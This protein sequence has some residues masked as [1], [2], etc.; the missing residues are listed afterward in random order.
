MSLPLERYE[1]KQFSF[2]TVMQNGHVMLAKDK[3]YYSVP[4]QYIRKK[5]K[6]V[7]TSGKVEI[8]HKYNRIATHAR[9]LKPYNYTTIVEHLASAHQFV[10]EWTPQRFINW[11]ASIDESVKESIIGLLENKQHPEQAYKSCMGV[12]SF[13]K[14]VGNERLINACKRALD[15][16]IYNY[17]I[18]QKILQNGLDQ[19]NDES[20]QDQELPFHQNIRGEKYYR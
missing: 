16:H 5:V 6:L 3:H 20:G 7:Y 17:K 14:K 10:T 2:A 1:I 12:L 18:I 9:H 11:A 15:H 8:F 19:L 4:Y 13:A